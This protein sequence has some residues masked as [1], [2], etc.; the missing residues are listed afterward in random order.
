MISTQG[1][2]TLLMEWWEG[3]VWCPL[4]CIVKSLVI[5]VPGEFITGEYTP[6]ICYLE[7]IPALI[8]VNICP[9][10]TWKN[11]PGA[12]LHL[13]NIKIYGGL[14]NIKLMNKGSQIVNGCSACDAYSMI[15]LI[16]NNCVAQIY[17][18][19]IPA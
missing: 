16:L 1:T 10:F 19:Q 2:K 8:I 6:Y 15:K 17:T 14:D 5:I 13:Y 4:H 9:T 11:D 7:N 18:I 12:N 3:M